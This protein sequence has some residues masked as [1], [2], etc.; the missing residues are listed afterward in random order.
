MATGSSVLNQS[1]FWRTCILAN[2]GRCFCAHHHT[3][4]RRVARRITNLC[5]SQ[6]DIKVV[7]DRTQ[8]LK[9]HNNFRRSDGITEYFPGVFWSCEN[10]RIIDAADGRCHVTALCQGQECFC[11]PVKEG[12]A[13]R[14]AVRDRR[15]PS[16]SRGLPWLKA[17]GFKLAHAGSDLTGVLHGHFHKK[18][19]CRISRCPGPMQSMGL[20]RPER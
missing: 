16:S 12:I 20:Q 11:V 15:A 14:E 8:S 19:R 2:L 3:C 17:H 7:A 1:T 9:L 6:W 13:V 4:N 5:G 18:V 10:A